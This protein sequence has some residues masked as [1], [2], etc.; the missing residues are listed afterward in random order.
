MG[1][2]SVAAVRHRASAMTKDEQA[3][4]GFL[5]GYFHQDWSMDSLD[6]RGV[7]NLFLQDGPPPETLQAIVRALNQLAGSRDDAV[8]SQRLLKEFGCYYYPGAA[9]G[10][11][12]DWLLELAEVLHR[13]ARAA[14]TGGDAAPS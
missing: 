2:S 8:L 14:P 11:V 7:A 3:L 9:P 12:R 4:A 10:V 6:W 1:S 5:T 13:A